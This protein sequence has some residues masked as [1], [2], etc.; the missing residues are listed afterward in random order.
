MASEEPNTESTPLLD[1]VQPPPSTPKPH[2]HVLRVVS[3]CIISIFLIEIG[4]YMQKAPWTR[5]LED[6]VCRSYFTS[7]NPTLGARW[8]PQIPE[9]D[10]KVAPVQVSLLSY[11]LTSCILFRGGSCLRSRQSHLSLCDGAPKL[12]SFIFLSSHL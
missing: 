9:Q 4:D 6:I 10:C 5:I 1:H 8:E 11:V 7:Q 12:S 2:P 3:I